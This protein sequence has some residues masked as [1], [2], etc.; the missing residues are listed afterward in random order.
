MKVILLYPKWTNEYGITSHFARKSGVFPPMNLAYL[1]S[2]AENLGHEVKIVDGEV[3]KMSIEKMISGVVYFNPDIIGFTASTPFFHVVSNVAYRLKEV[4]PNTPILL[5]GHH[6]TVLREKAFDNC[7]D[8]GFIGEADTSFPLFLEKYEKGEG[9]NKVPGILFRNGK[10]IKY[11]NDVLPVLDMDSLPI[12]AYHL[13]KMGRY[14][15]GT[16]H[17]TKNFSSIMTTRGCPFKCI[18]CS[19]KVFGNSV[20]RRSPELVIEE[21]KYVKNIFGIDHFVFM[22]DVITLNREHILKIC[23]KI[24]EEDINITFEGATR[25]NLIDEEIISKMSEVGLIRL[26]FG[27]ESVDKNIQRIMRKGIPLKDYILANKITNKYNIETLNSCMI[28]LPGETKQTIKKTLSFLRDSH[29]IKQANVSI[30][31]PYPGTSLYEMAKNVDY[32]LKLIK[33]DFSQFMRYDNAVMQVGD[34]SPEE[35]IKL[36]NDAFASIYL[37]Y[38]RWNSVIKKFGLLGLILTF[39]R[40]MKSIMRGRFEL[41]MVNRE[42]WRENK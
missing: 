30:A 32:G 34:L 28:G 42:Y 29:D 11:T 36:Q 18:F 13:L 14:K 15:I 16:L 5:G 8:Y 37:A 35:L 26:T 31:V 38:W 27:L 20:Y 9:I 40:I 7:F 23:E 21:I 12:P 6:I 41:L 19:T 3:E 24:K 39:S 33:N 2:L 4:L 17:G 25:A 22:D 10:N 1:A